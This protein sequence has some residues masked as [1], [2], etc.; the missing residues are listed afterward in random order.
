M[1]LCLETSTAVCSVA[2]AQNGTCLGQRKAEKPMSHTTTLSVLIEDLL[3]DKELTYQDLQAVAVCKGPG[4]Y[5]GLRT[6]YATAQGLCLALDIPLIEV[7]VMQVLYF[8]SKQATSFKQYDEVI[9]VIDARRMEYYASFHRETYSHDVKSWIPNDK[10]FRTMAELGQN[11]LIAGNG[12]GKIKQLIPGY[13]NIDLLE[14]DPEA[15]GMCSIAHE[16]YLMNNF[17][18]LSQAEPDYFKPPNIT[19][20]KKISFH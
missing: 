9:T 16:T 5:T 7:S 13:S 3:R 2:L 19:K 20:S 1:I 15:F 10:T 11:M 12:L 14:I 18:D 8:I 17:C 4:S 6:A